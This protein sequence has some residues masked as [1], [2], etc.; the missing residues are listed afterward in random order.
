MA[1][2]VSPDLA[3]NA[4]VPV[5]DSALASQL[6]LVPKSYSAP[7]YKLRRF[8][9]VSGGTSM[10]LSTSNTLSQFN[11]PGDSVWNLSRSYLSLDVVSAGNA[12]ANF[13]NTF[14]SDNFPIDSI[15][16]Q[17]SSGQVL[18]NIQN[19]QVYSKTARFLCTDS[20]EYSSRGS[21]FGDTVLGT[22]F[23]VSINQGCQPARQQG[24][25]T[26]LNLLPSRPMAGY[27]TNAGI[28][29]VVPANQA[30]GVDD[31]VNLPQRVISGAFTGNAG[32]GALAVRYKV[33]LGAFVG[34]ILS[35]DKD[36]YF[37][38][39]LQLVIYW[40]PIANWGF[41]SDNA[42]AAT[43]ALAIPVISNYFLYMSQ[44]VN[45]ENVDSIKSQVNS[46]GLA[47]LVPYTNCSQLSTAGAGTYTISTPLT[48]GMG[49]AL[50]RVLTAPITSTNTLATTA[51]LDNVNGVKWTQIQS[52]LDGKPIQ[53]FP[54]LPAN[55]DV[56]NYMYP[57]LK[58]TPAGITMRNF[59]ICNFFVDN[60][61]DCDDGAKFRE[62]DCYESG[63]SVDIQKT[64]EVQVVGAVAL[65]LMQYQTWVRKLIIQ[66]N[67][68]SW[69]V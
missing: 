49:V 1:S 48:P 59:E 67:S 25:Q 62:N 64:Y 7:V 42:L 47:L 8:T 6:N 65:T 43:A 10:T 26:T 22:A 44:D 51:N 34:T 35:L 13:G 52:T 38:Q 66:P 56:W 50:K 24:A 4:S 30:S 12:T 19:A 28:V 39:N 40:K 68:I 31:I 53:D 3:V 5:P 61:S 41:A 54:L 55:S 23:P 14:F 58:N 63:L 37:G 18:A 29:N 69:G 46:G 15:Q 2:I 32:T 45:Q 33:S 27:L 17:T 60:F 16:L 9:Q 21:S 57:I 20:D 36:L 11:I